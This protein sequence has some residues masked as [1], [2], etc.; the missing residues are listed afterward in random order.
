MLM[1]DPLRFFMLLLIFNKI[2]YLLIDQ[3]GQALILPYKYYTLVYNK[4]YLPDM[5]Y[6]FTWIS[7]F[8]FLVL[9]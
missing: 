2:Q 8:F 9:L 7:P 5:S 3:I 1:F 6:D 4:Y